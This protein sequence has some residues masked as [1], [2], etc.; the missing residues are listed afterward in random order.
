MLKRKNG[1]EYSL[2]CLGLNIVVV[3]NN[4]TTEIE[5]K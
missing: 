4:N 5:N 1:E 3:K 2:S